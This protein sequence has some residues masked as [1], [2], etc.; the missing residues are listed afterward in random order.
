M[1][2]SIKLSS[3][4]ENDDDDEAKGRE[5]EEG[6]LGNKVARGMVR[7]GSMVRD[8]S[9][10]RKKKK[11]KKKK[12]KMKREFHFKSS[13]HIAVTRRL[14]ILTI[15]FVTQLKTNGFMIFDNFNW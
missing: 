9:V 3:K 1:E 4:P 12:K 11:K 8:G 6:C 7:E 2:G 15:R 5:R 10:V 13:L 14:T